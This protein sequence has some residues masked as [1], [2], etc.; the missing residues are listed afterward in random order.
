[1]LAEQE[2]NDLATD[3]APH[4]LKPPLTV[5]SE[6]KYLLDGR[7][8]REACRRAGVSP[9]LDYLPEEEDPVAFII[10]ANLKRRH[11]TENQRAH[12]AAEIANLSRGRKSAN[13]PIYQDGEKPQPVTQANAAKALNVSDRSLRRTIKVKKHG[14][15]ELRD[16]VRDGKI[17][18]SRAAKIAELLAEE[19]RAAMA[20]SPHPGAA[21]LLN[22]AGDFLFAAGS[23]RG[24]PRRYGRRRKPSARSAF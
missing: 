22:G 15:P 3:I 23:D 17:K 13:W 21:K 16:A 4:G 11:L 7:N 10:S 12:I 1:M 2:L 6:V 18:I 8:R 20:A 9:M 24:G 14:I 5:D 19:Q